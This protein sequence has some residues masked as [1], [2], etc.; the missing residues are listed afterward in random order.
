MAIRHP[1]HHAADPNAGRRL[2]QGRQGDPSLQTGAV[3]IPLKR[4]EM[5]KV[6][7]RFKEFNLV[8][9]PPDIQHIPPTGMLRRRLNP[10]SHGPPPL[11]GFESQPILTADYGCCLQVP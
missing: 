4:V 2:S 7:G 3:L 9:S 5:V 10:K 11:N 8:S 1:I 6:P